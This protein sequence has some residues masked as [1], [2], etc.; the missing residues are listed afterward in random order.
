MFRMAAYIRPYSYESNPGNICGGFSQ[1][2]RTLPVSFGTKTKSMT[3]EKQFVALLNS[4]G[5]SLPNVIE[6]LKGNLAVSREN[7]FVVKGLMDEETEVTE[8]IKLLE[9]EL[10][11]AVLSKLA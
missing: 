9:L 5:L 11:I 3:R 2:F 10:F 6:T 4:Y 7:Y 1:I 8:R